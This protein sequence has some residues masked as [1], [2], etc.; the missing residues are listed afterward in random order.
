MDVHVRSEKTENTGIERKR[1]KSHRMTIARHPND[2]RLEP[3]QAGLLLRSARLAYEYFV[4]YLGYLYFGTG[5]ALISLF[6][7]ALYSLIP[8]TLGARFGRWMTGLYFRSFLALLRFSGLVHIDLTA[9]D[10]L[11]GKRSI[12]IAPNHPSLL[13]AVLVISRLPQV[14]CIM[15]AEIWDSFFLGGGARLS[16][17][18]RN[19]SPINMVRLST[20]QLRTGHQLLV[21][22][23]GTRTRSLPINAFKGGF[24][25]MAKKSGA[26]IQTIFIETNT[27]FLNKG[28]PMLKKPE[29]P[30][31]YRARL[32]KCFRVTGNVAQFVSE[33]ESYYHRELAVPAPAEP[34]ASDPVDTPDS[35][36]SASHGRQ[37]ADEKKLSDSCPSRVHRPH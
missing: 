18:I 16:R 17:Y 22:P 11:R 23:E 26:E 36:R 3:V 24:A 2:V 33:L 14:A 34:S 32:G 37:T 30:L 6:S 12:I 5:S 27:T 13:D 7:T 20:K 28:W 29:F 19:D 15:K 9:L 8:D 31:T 4:F 10:D 25:L 21:F 1:T 35:P